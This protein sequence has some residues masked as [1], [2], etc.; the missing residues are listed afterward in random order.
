VHVEPR[1]PDPDEFYARL[2][3]MHEGLN[4]QQSLRLISRR[5]LLLANQVGDARMLDEVLAA[6]SPRAGPHHQQTG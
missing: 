2:V 1:I 3:A 6:A 5:V 4:Q